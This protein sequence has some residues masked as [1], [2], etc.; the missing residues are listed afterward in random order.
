MFRIHLWFGEDSCSCTPFK[1]WKMTWEEI[2]L[3]ALGTF[4]RTFSH[5][6]ISTSIKTPWTRIVNP[7]LT[8]SAANIL[9]LFST[10]SVF[11]SAI[12][13]QKNQCLKKIWMCRSQLSLFSRYLDILDLQ[14]AYSSHFQWLLE[15]VLYIFLALWYFTP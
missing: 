9:L 1:F 7:Q 8:E 15:V 13:Q 3:S 6:Q 14:T 10:F 11:P 4:S 12:N 5:L 2:T